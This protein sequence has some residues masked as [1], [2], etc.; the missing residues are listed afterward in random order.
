MDETDADMV[1]GYHDGLTDERDALPDSLTN[2]SAAYIHGWLNGRDDRLK[3]PRQSA[4]SG[5]AKAEAIR[6]YAERGLY[7]PLPTL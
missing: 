6:R 4:V 2:R 1:E 7:G 5:R 3:L